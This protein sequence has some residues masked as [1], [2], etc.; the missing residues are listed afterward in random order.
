MRKIRDGQPIATN[1][2]VAKPRR[3]I[4]LH[5]AVRFLDELGRTDLR[6]SQDTLVD[7]CYFSLL[8]HGLPDAAARIYRAWLE[9]AVPRAWARAYPQA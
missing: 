1:R 5:L 6:D 3:A 4:G 2:V 7:D 9:L 8:R